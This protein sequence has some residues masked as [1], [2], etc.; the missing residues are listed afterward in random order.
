MY[1]EGEYSLDYQLSKDL[2]LEK[3]NASERSTLLESGGDIID[4][5]VKSNEDK[6]W[7]IKISKNASVLNL[8]RAIL[9]Y[10]YTGVFFFNQQ[11]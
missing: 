6:I 9:T 7:T 1:E 10:C 3:I 8:K 5:K 2:T 11:V 4:L